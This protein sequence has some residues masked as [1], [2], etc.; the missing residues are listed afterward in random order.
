MI[1]IGIVIGG[2]LL[3]LEPPTIYKYSLSEGPSF[4]YCRITKAS[5]LLPFGYNIIILGAC[6]VHYFKGFSIYQNLRKDGHYWNDIST[7]VWI[8]CPI[9]VVSSFN[10]KENKVS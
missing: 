9:F 7:G 10:Y 8:I 2:I 5:T 3:V 6:L 4:S 1:T